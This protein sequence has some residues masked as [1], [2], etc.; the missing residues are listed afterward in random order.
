MKVNE[1]E[2]AV[3]E[4][5]KQKIMT[6]YRHQISKHR[7]MSL[8]E[9]K[10]KNGPVTVYFDEKLP[11]L[12]SVRDRMLWVVHGMTQREIGQKMGIAQT[13]VSSMLRPGRETK[14]QTLRRFSSVFGVPLEWL[15]GKNNNQVK[16]KASDVCETGNQVSAKMCF[17]ISD[18]LL[19]E[20]IKKICFPVFDELEYDIQIK[21]MLPE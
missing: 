5:M 2:E 18:R 9:M 6:G 16:N 7:E 1:I 17:E 8:A 13:S 14:E 4:E 3:R 10:A 21:V 20:Q 12:P 15:K 11:D 19:G